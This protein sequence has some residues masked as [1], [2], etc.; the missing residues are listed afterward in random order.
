MSTSLDGFPILKYIYLCMCVA[1][2]PTNAPPLG[3]GGTHHS[4][5]L[6]LHASKIKCETR[7]EHCGVAAH[8]A[9]KLAVKPAVT[10]AVRVSA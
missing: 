2:S 1:Y 8:L 9:V 3:D 4:P 7:V 6:L 5:S 10:P